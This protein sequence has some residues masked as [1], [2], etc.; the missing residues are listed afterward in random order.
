MHLLL[1]PHSRAPRWG[2]CP[3]QGSALPGGLQ[4]IAPTPLPIPQLG[5]AAGA[6]VVPSSAPQRRGAAGDC[7]N[8]GGLGVSPKEHQTPHL[9]GNN[10]SGC[11]AGSPSVWV[12]NVPCCSGR[13][14]WAPD[15]GIG[16]LGGMKPP[17]GGEDRHG[18]CPRC[19]WPHRS[20]PLGPAAPRLPGAAVGE[21]GGS[22]IPAAGGDGARP[23]GKQG[24]GYCHRHGR[25]APRSAAHKYRLAL[26][27]GSPGAAAAE[28]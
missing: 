15:P 20:S 5:L 27:R 8:P 23:P 12:T 6:L 2:T 3:L 9:G 21:D 13:G 16:V 4:A 26:L 11:G 22:R 28:Q 17:E 25:L 19:A 10:L 1:P 18:P 24:L 7:T 14:H